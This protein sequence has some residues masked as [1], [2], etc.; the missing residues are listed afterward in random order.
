MVEPNTKHLSS[1]GPS[2]SA[3]AF[4]KTWCAKDPRSWPPLLGAACRDT[5]THTSQLAC[6]ISATWTCVVLIAFLDVVRPVLDNVPLCDPLVEL[7]SSR[8]SPLMTMSTIDTLRGCVSDSRVNP[9]LVACR[10]TAT[11]G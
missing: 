3:C 9:L 5:T 11:H 8:G 10:V 6:Q 2:P 4:R 1:T 7:N